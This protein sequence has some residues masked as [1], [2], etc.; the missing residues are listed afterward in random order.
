M[1]EF[2]QYQPEKHGPPSTV[3]SDA[4]PESN[5]RIAASSFLVWGE[6]CTECAAPACFTTCDLYQPRPDGQCRRFAF[7]VYRN[8]NFDSVR[9]YGAEIAFKKWAKLEA[10]GNTHMEPVDRVLRRE[11]TV[12]RLAPATGW[13]G[14]VAARISRDARFNSLAFR[15]LERYQRWK[16]RRKTPDYVPSAFVLEVYNP[17]GTPVNMQLRMSISHAELGGVDPVTLPPPFATTVTLP[18]G[19]SRR[20]I[21]RVLFQSVTEAGLPFD[22]S[23]TPEADSAAHLIFLAADFVTFEKPAIA[24]AGRPAVKCVVFDLDNTVWDGILLESDE[25]KLR[26]GL[27]Q[28]LRTLDERGI[29]LSIASKNSHDHAWGKL[30]ELGIAEYFLYAKIN[31]MPKSEN[32]RQIA[33]DLNIGLDTFVFVDD[34]AFER[35]QVTRALPGVACVSDSAMFALLDDPLLAGGNTDEARNR[36]KLYQEAIERE[37]VLTSYG[38]DYFAFLAACRTRLTMAEYGERDLERASELV[39]RTNQLNFSGRK[40]RREEIPAILDD[41]GLSKFVLRCSDKFGAYGVVGFALVRADGEVL[42]VEDFMLSCRVQGKFVEQAFFDWISRN[43]RFGSPRR[44]WINFRAT[45]KNTPARQV[46]ET[47]GFAPVDGEEGLSIDLARTSL[48]CDFIEVV[49]EDG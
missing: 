5:G 13:L 37:T 44:L 35:E 33:S 6:H 12:E 10:R 18:P 41:P 15:L 29:L 43:P 36:R 30:E 11:R 7:G 45:G 9:G 48:R 42:R 19:F 49:A 46:L 40:Y 17:T 20:E 4:V 21:D 3:R 25:V 39:Q 47:I 1:Y 22:V 23:L 14:A 32:I 8:R 26:D 16:H 38:D 2:D 28:L 24:A 27:P 31:W 34:N